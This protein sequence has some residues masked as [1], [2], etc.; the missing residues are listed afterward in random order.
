M[1]K[2]AWEQAAGAFVKLAGGDDPAQQ[3]LNERLGN[4][5]V[6]VVVGH[7]IADA[8]SRP[9]QREFAQVASSQNKAVLEVCQPEQM[10]GAFAGLRRFQR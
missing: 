6:D 9:P 4:A 7:M 10:R 2:M 8:V 3:V 5:G 1:S